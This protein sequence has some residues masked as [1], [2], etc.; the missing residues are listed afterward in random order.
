MSTV[1][2]MTDNFGDYESGHVYRVRTRNAEDMKVAEVATPIV[3]EPIPE[4]TE[5]GV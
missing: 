5:E 2:E 1:V 3:N 4:E